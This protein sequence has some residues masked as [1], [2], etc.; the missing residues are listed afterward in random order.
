MLNFVLYHFE[1]KDDFD[2]SKYYDMMICYGKKL[3]DNVKNDQF[4]TVCLL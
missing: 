3:V 2:S 4:S 1:S